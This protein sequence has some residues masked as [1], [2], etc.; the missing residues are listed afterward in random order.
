MITTHTAVTAVSVACDAT[1]CDEHAHYP[2]RRGEEHPELN[3][4]EEFIR[5]GWR[6]WTFPQTEFWVC[7]I[8]DRKLRREA[9]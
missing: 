8:H 9:R 2:A 6:A 1:P 3:A 5:T 4:R 7:P